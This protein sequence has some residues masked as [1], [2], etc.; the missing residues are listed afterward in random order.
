MQINQTFEINMFLFFAFDEYNYFSMILLPC[1]WC[2]GLIAPM[3]LAN[4]AMIGDVALLIDAM[5]AF[6]G[7]T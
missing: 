1:L 7:L 4:D 3:T 5:T 2:D 6:V